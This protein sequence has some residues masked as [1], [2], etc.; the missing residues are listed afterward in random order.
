MATGDSP[1][2]P[3]TPRERTLRI[4][5][6]RRLVERGDYLVPAEDVAEDLLRH[7]G[8]FV[9]APLAQQR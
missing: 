3:E 7:L 6:L 1:A 8:L 5:L 2:P 9:G 4:R